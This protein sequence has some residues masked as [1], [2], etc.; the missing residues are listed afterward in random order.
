[1]TSMSTGNARMPIYGHSYASESIRAGRFFIGA[2][3]GPPPRMTAIP[4][5]LLSLARAVLARSNRSRDSARDKRGT[6]TKIPSHE[7]VGPGTAKSVANQSENP[8]VPLSQALGHG[9]TGHA[10]KS[11]TAGGTGVPSSSKPTD[12]NKLSRTPKSS[13]RSGANRLL[14]SAGQSKNCSA[15]TLYLPDPRRTSDDCHGMTRRG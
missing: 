12:G 2:R 6:S 14:P 5:E 4:N 7:S 13:F 11:G 15:C 1:M 8:A 9:T 10:E 3:C